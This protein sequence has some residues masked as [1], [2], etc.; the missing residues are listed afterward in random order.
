MALALVGKIK[1]RSVCHFLRDGEQMVG[2]AAT[3]HLR[4]PDSSVSRTHAKIDLADDRAVLSDMK[5]SNGTF[6]NGARISKP[7][8]IE[9]GDIIGFADVSLK[10]VESDPPVETMY[11][12]NG[13]SIESSAH[14]PAAQSGWPCCCSCAIRAQ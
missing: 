12:Q 8:Q 3:S 9:I 10:L 14:T 6:V 7:R 1:G 13:S 11:A 4:L 5:S 2:R